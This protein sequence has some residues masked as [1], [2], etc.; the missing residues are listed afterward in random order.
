MSEI[1]KDI[2]LLHGALGNAGTLRPLANALTEC[3][4]HLFDLPGH[5]SDAGDAFTAD[6]CAAAIG[7]F[8]ES[9][10]LSSYYIFGY[11]MGG[12]AAL[13][14]AAG[15]QDR[16]QGIV[17]LGTKL[18]WSPE[19]A[20]AETRRLNPEIVAEKVPAFAGRL[21]SLHGSDWG[22]LMRRTAEMMEDLGGRRGLSSGELSRIAVP[23]LL[24]R[25]A[26]DKMVTQQETDAAAALVKNARTE[27]LP[28]TPHPIEQVDAEALA[29]RI[30]AFIK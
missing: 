2:I 10:G 15:R 22:G 25:G 24:L 21:E 5:G 13:Q 30:L 3:R 29:D 17:T 26:E 19:A 8:V 14:F 7:R 16:L 27:E 23:V 9:E 1:M 6:D 18:D 11:S 20:A 4:T 12:F 28:A